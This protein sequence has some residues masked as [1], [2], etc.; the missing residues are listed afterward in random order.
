VI[1]PLAGGRLILRSSVHDPGI[2]YLELTATNLKVIF[3]V[4]VKLTNVFQILNLNTLVLKE[5]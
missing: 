4:D 5:T 3:S 1:A 2:A